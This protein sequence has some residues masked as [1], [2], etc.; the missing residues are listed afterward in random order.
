VELDI[1]E[2]LAMKMWAVRGGISQCSI[3]GIFTMIYGS[4]AMMLLGRTVSGRHYPKASGQIV[5]ILFYP[6][7]SRVLV[8]GFRG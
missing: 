1:F 3:T 4:R 6:D 2:E 8:A 7:P 5:I